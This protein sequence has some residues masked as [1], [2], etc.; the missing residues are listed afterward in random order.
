MPVPSTYADN[1]NTKGDTMTGDSTYA[2]SEHKANFTTQIAMIKLHNKLME[3]YSGP[4]WS[5]DYP[6]GAEAVKRGE[7]RGYIGMLADLLD[8]AREQEA[9]LTQQG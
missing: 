3:L 5:H 6:H 8:Q 9:R 1:L 4:R 2:S 7:V